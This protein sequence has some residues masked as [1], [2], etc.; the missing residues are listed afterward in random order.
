[1]GW[2]RRLGIGCGGIFA[3][4]LIGGGWLWYAKPWVPPVEVAMPGNGGVR[5]T[6]NGMIGNFYAGSGEGPRPALLLFGGSEGGINSRMEKMALQFRDAGISVLIISWYRASGQSDKIDRIPL[7]TFYTA[8][9]WLKKQPA[10]DPTRVAIMGGSKGGEAALLVA[11]RRKDV[12][13]VVAGMPSHVA[14]QGFDW[15]MS[16]VDHSS[17]SEGGKETAYLPITGGFGMDV[18]TPSLKEEGRYPQ[19][20][21]PVEHVAGP[22]ILLCG[23]A[24]SLW[25]S[26]PMAR[27]LEDRA[28][29]QSGPPVTLL[30]YKNAGHAVFG[31]P[32]AKGDPKI[33]KLSTLGGTGEGNNAARADAWPKIFAFLNEQLRP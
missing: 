11:S 12:T 31:L 10:I 27:K 19:A 15:N 7:E 5:M 25:P 1:M 18:Y 16:V 29:A 6:D 26:C 23:E 3:L 14:W 20:I 9:D 32:L 13:A 33:E 24:D 28:K 2:K 30:A 4:A 8:L 22:I 21:I 17:W